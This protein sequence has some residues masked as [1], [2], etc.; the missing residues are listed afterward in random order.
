MKILPTKIQLILFAT[1]LLTASCEEESD[2]AIERVVAPV[3]IQ[4]ED[5]SPVEIVATF[6]ELDKTGILDHTVGIDSVAVPNL[7]VEVLAANQTIGKFITAPDGSI[8]VSYTGIKP[9]EYAG[10][11]KGIA[12]RIKK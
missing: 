3:V 7:E 8:R 1:V 9:N 12:F 6:Y 10:I 5:V 4:I 11:H 2:M